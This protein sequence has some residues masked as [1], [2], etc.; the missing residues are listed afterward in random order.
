MF[1]AVLPLPQAHLYLHDPLSE[2]YSFCPDNMFKVDFAF[3][4]GKEIVAVE[5]DGESHVGNREHVRKDRLM[6][7]A[8]VHVVHILNNEIR[9]FAQKT[10]TKLLPK[11]IV[12]FWKF[13]EYKHRSNPLAKYEIPF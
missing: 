11:E 2:K 4:T 10:I 7:R 12:E 8:G 3:W 9:E 1:D 5:I 6:Q 13:S